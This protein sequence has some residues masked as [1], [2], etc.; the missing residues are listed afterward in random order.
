MRRSLSF[1]LMMLLS[2]VSSA[3]MRWNQRYQSYIDEYKDLAI[4]E[5]L[6]YNIPA[7]ITLAQGLFESAAGTSELTRK[8][9]NHFGIKCHGW[10]GAV[11]YHDDD[12]EQECFR[13][14]NNAYESFE[15][16]SKFLARQPRYSRLF[17]LS[18]TDYKGWARGL[19]ECGYATNPS[20]AKKLIDIIEL[21]RL[22]QYDHARHYDRFMA[23]HASKDKP[24]SRGGTLHAI[25]MY[26]KNYYVIARDGDTWKSLGKEIGISYRKIAK[27]NERDRHDAIV[28]GERIYLKKK[29]RRAEKRFKGQPHVVKGGESMYSIAQLYGIRLKNLYSKNRLSPTYQIAAGD[30]LKVY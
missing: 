24:A 5:M 7:S 21:Y 15:D 27:Y 26:N 11:T 1:V 30:K 28:P 17:R 14:Y 29:Q 10:G 9:N 23:R 16:H 19:K 20:Y 3:Q 22:D 8:G 18:R 13:A 4:E 25:T 12:A 6:R 2:V